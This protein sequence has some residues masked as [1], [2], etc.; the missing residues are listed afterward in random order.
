MQVLITRT[1]VANKQFVREGSTVDL[2]DNEAKQLIALGKAVAVGG[3]EPASETAVETEAETESVEAEGD[4]L[5]TE[6]AEAVV[7]T[8]APKSKRRGA[9]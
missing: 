1:T 8:A 2:D 6:N 9:K 7:A 3:D 5:T 4:E